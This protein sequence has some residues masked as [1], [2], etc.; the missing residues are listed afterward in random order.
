MTETEKIIMYAHPACPMVY[1]VKSILEGAG[2]AYDYINIHEDSQGRE[3]V[4]KINQWL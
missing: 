3:I 1:P 2:V 4:R